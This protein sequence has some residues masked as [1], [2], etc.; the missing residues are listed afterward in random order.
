MFWIALS[1]R[2][3]QLAQLILHVLVY[4]L[5]EF[6][7]AHSLA[8]M[9]FLAGSKCN[10]FWGLEAAIGGHHTSQ[11]TKYIFKIIEWAMSH[12]K[13]DSFS[14]CFYACKMIHAGSEHSD[15]FSQKFKPL[16]ILWKSSFNF[17]TRAAVSRFSTSDPGLHRL[18]LNNLTA[19]V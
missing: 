10:L 4:V 6:I 14:W 15:D 12:Q 9:L 8:A 17:F 13:L 7:A 3:L 2:E 18:W 1:A 5:L 11:S 19:S 16:S